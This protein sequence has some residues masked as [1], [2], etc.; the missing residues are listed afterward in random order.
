MIVSKPKPSALAALGIFIL[1]CLSVGL[2]FL[3]IS[4]REGGLWYQYLGVFILLSVSFMLFLRQIV[5]YKIVSI[6]DNK[7]I[8]KYPLIGKRRELKAMQLVSWKEV[9][10]KTKSAPFRQLEIRFSDFLLKL[11][12]QENTSYEQVLNYLK[13]KLGKKEAT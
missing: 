5:G 3:Q 13:K 7:F 11:T 9:V 10:V 6:G 1:I 12:I 2:Y 8:V 4:V